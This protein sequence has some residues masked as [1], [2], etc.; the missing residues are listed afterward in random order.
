MDYWFLQLILQQ[1]D[2]LWVWLH[3]NDQ[4]QSRHTLRASLYDDSP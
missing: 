3:A 2:Y 4:A 1:N